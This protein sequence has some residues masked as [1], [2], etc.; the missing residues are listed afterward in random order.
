MKKLIVALLNSFTTAPNNIS[1]ET[2]GTPAMKQ[3]LEF[4][5]VSCSMNMEIADRKI[6][7]TS[8]KNMVEM[9]VNIVTG[10]A[11]DVML[12]HDNKERRLQN[13]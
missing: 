8:G 6:G 9:V 10:K 2:V 7:R 5:S 4:K 11:K 3:R 1:E 12:R 13:V